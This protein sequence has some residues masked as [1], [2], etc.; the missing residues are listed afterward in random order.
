MV[1][2]TGSSS[3]SNVG[4]ADEWD[5]GGEEAETVG[6][7]AMVDE[8]ADWPILPSRPADEAAD[9]ARTAQ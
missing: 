4:V 7:A 2:V 6:A 8:A 1:V 5:A 9:M 3:V